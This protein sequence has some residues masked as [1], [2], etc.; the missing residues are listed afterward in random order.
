M[1]TYFNQLTEYP[2]FGDW[3][4]Q[5]EVECPKYYSIWFTRQKILSILKAYIAFLG[6]PLK[7]NQKPLDKARNFVMLT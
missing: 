3:L 2:L 5:Q 6:M 4:A 1:K 7:I